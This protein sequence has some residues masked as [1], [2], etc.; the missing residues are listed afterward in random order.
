VEVSST[1]CVAIAN[2]G[3]SIGTPAPIYPGDTVDFSA[4]IVPNS[5]DKPYT[6]TVDYGDGTTPIT[7]TS[8]ADPLP[9][10]H[11]FADPGDYVVNVGAWNCAMTSPATDLVTV[12]VSTPPVPLLGVDLTVVTTG[13]IYISDTVDFSADF[14]PNDAAKP[15]T[16]TVDYGDGTPPVTASTS[17]DP[18]AL[19]HAY[20]LTGTF[21]VA[22]SAWNTNPDAPV[23]DSLQ[24]TVYEPGVCL[25]L[26][27]I[28]IQGPTTG[29]PGVYTFTTAF[30]P[31]DATLPITYSWDNGDA[32]ASSIRT[33]D[34]GS[35]TLVV[36]ATNCAL[37]PV[38][39][40]HSIEISDP[41]TDLLSVDRPVIG[42]D[43]QRRYGG[44]QRRL[45]R[46]TP[47][48]TFTLDFGDG[49][50]QFAASVK[51]RWPSPTHLH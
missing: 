36:T 22:I 25:P 50:A 20:T 21:T 11:A 30:L 15:I 40:E 14:T 33:L 4:D 51:I 12:T 7:A 38:T 1:A 5:A 26:D 43:L 35:Y 47:K 18:L 41:Y 32:T 9:L 16:Y 8:S 23:T 34:V 42:Y 3:L 24:L 45:C 27:S 29:A 2:L 10:T 13:T 17:S 49:S 6:Y 39:D 37:S 28:T 31:L 46:M 48:P 44:L 19:A